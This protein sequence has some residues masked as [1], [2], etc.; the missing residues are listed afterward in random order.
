MP[1]DLVISCFM[2]VSRALFISTLLMLISPA[3]Y[4]A[5]TKVISGKCSARTFS[6][7]FLTTMVLVMVTYLI[8]EM[9]FRLYLWFDT[10]MRYLDII[11][12]IFLIH[13]SLY[14]LIGV[15]F[16]IRFHLYAHRIEV[17]LI[18]TAAIVPMVNG[19]IRLS[20]DVFV[21]QTYVILQ[22]VEAL[23]YILI[24]FVK[25]SM[26]LQW[27]DSRFPRQTIN[28]RDVENVPSV[29]VG[30]ILPWRVTS[31]QTIAYPKTVLGSYHFTNLESCKDLYSSE[32]G[33]PT[34]STKDP[35]EY[36]N[37]RSATMRRSKIQPSIA[38]NDEDTPDSV[39][40]IQG[41]NIPVAAYIIQTHLDDNS[42][43]DD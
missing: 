34:S 8:L 26:A 25:A 2:A 43:Y 3:W 14:A 7:L 33:T 5:I 23:S 40:A 1:D 4:F 13:I 32:V 15:A 20:K 30:A 11:I 39:T 29:N 27:E 17:V 18:L 16:M 6:A 36:D 10:H 42:Q 35:F 22:G 12:G 9:T 21:D 37:T 19:S 31:S 28:T 41:T 24:L 38:I